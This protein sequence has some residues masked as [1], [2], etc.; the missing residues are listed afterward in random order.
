MKNLI[1]TN[2]LIQESKENQDINKKIVNLKKKLIN[3]TEKYEQLK[4]DLIIVRQEY[5]IRIGRL[6]LKIDELDL[7]I[8]KNKKIEEL[9]KENYSKEEA[10][11]IVEESLKIRQEKINREFGKYEEEEDLIEK[12]KNISKEDKEELKK[13]RRELLFIYH[14]DLTTNTDDRKKCE[15]IM[16][17]INEAYSNSDIEALKKIQL[18]HLNISENY[19][20]QSKLMNKIK[21]LENA[22]VSINN[23]YLLLKKSEWYIWKFNIKKAKGY[24]RDLLAELEEKLIED[25]AVKENYLYESQKKYESK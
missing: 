22:I 1:K 13:V 10:I 9:L 8:L 12:E 21:N 14:P 6:Y 4:N 16:K 7:E 19:D 24:G 18:E 3:L 20:S 11:R 15:E 23:E 2:N 17:K 25:I 5:E